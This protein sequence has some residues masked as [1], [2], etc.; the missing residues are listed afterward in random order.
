VMFRTSQ[1]LEERLIQQ[2]QLVQTQLL[3]M[4]RQMNQQLSQNASVVQD[5]TKVMGEFQRRLGQLQESTQSMI[6][7]GQDISSLQDILQAPKLR[8]I[9]GE[10]F[11]EEILKQILPRDRYELQHSFRSGEKVDAVIHLAQGMVPVDAKFPLENFRRLIQ[12]NAPE[13]ESLRRRRQ[14]YQDV[15]RHIDN[16][17]A[18]YILPEEGTFDFALMY[19]PAENVYYEVILKGEVREGGPSLVEYALDRKVIPVSP[20]TFYAYLQAIVVGLRG[21]RIESSAKEILKCLGQLAG[22]FRKFYE[23][24]EI[25]GRH[26][27]NSKA[28]FDKAQRRLDRFQDQLG[29]IESQDATPALPEGI[30]PP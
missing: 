4:S 14:F 8:G 29:S 5:Y 27:V 15:K 17:A 10:F 11:L 9:L 7:I 20:N 16:I 22:D 26:L 24:F 13:E 6:R 2:N 19:L 12:P 18:K 30:S 25:L 3:E 23:E 21:L 1:K 28:T